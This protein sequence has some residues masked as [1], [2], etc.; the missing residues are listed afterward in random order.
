MEPEGHLR[1]PNRPNRPGRK[2]PPRKQAIDW[3]P[4]WRVVLGRLDPASESFLPPPPS[5]LGPRAWQSC[6]ERLGGRHRAVEKGPDLA[7][8]R[9]YV[10]T[11]SGPVIQAQKSSTMAKPTLILNSRKLDPT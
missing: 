10:Q 3:G 11:C 1:A 7:D 9:S 5:H 4:S 6:P 8:G 2:E